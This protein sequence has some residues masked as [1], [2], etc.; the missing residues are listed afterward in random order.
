MY[1]TLRVR[2]LDPCAVRKDFMALSGKVNLLDGTR[3]TYRQNGK[4][5]V[6][7]LEKSLRES[8]SN[9]NTESLVN[10][11]F[12][13]M[14]TISA[15]TRFKD[16]HIIIKGNNNLLK[17]DGES[18]DDNEGVELNPQK[19]PS[20]PPSQAQPERSWWNLWKF[21]IILVL[22]AINPTFHK[23]AKLKCIYGSNPIC[24]SDGITYNNVC[25]LQIV[26]SIYPELRVRHLGSCAIG[27]QFGASGVIHLI[28]GSGGRYLRKR[29]RK[30]KRYRMSSTDASYEENEFLK[31]Y[32]FSKL[33]NSVGTISAFNNFNME[34][35]S[36]GTTGNSNLFQISFG[37]PEETTAKPA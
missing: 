13:S 37:K 19:P 4:T 17:V 8:S 6:R 10:N 7:R 34:Q 25:D 14:G 11:L 1:P 24:G 32:L 30:N 18:Y 33:F 3:G 12:D 2:H 26:R 16:N 27:N 36:I 22:V 35:N 28:D 31:E 21:W 29:P 20:K 5:Q 15:F 9:K 23:A